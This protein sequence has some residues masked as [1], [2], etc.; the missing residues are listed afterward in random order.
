M[1]KLDQD[2]WSNQYETGSTQWDAGTITAPLKA[3]FEQVTDKDIAIL[4]PGCGN[5]HEAAFL[6][7]QGF[8]NV[9]VLDISQ[10]LCDRLAQKFTADTGK[11]VQIVCADFF[12]HTGQYD[13]IIEQTFFCALDP[14]LRTSYRDQVWRLLKP[15]GKLVGLLFDAELPDGPPFGGD[16]KL[17]TELFK[18]RFQVE[19][20]EPCYNSIEKRKGRELFIKLRKA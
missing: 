1:I 14:G 2:W 11:G 17:Y 10:V 12:Q 19:T 9:T 7:Q 18:D 16:K 4:V 8:T 15:N 13:L 3:Y 20:M 6:L 5:S